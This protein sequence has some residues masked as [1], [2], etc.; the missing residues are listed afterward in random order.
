MYFARA[1]V[2]TSVNIIRG[3]IEYSS[4]V[5]DNYRRVAELIF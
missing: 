1:K 4:G 2:N 5:H 3:Y